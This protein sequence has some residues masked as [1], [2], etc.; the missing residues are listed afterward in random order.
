MPEALLETNG[1][2]KV[3]PIRTTLVERLN[4]HRPTVVAANGVN[5]SIERG[6][7]VAL[8]GQSG[9]GKSTLGRLIARLEEP[10]SGQIILDGQVISNLRGNAL[11]QLRRR[12]QIIFQNPYEALD[13]RYTVL[14]S[15]TEPLQL[16]GLASRSERKEKAISALNDVGLKPP[17]RYLEAY[18]HELSGGQR[19]RVAIARALIVGP[20][21]VVADEAVS[22]LDASVRSGVMNLL[23][24]LQEKRG[25]S[26][27]FIT[28]D[29]AAARYMS[30]RV[31]VMHE[32]SIVEEGPTEEVI[33][34]PKHEYTR[35]LISAASVADPRAPNPKGKPDG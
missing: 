29:L 2:T 34:D 12:I 19:Q 32:G 17:E 15:V 13:P 8:V 3:Y 18:P 25:L 14:R 9:S 33:W 6:E 5:L 11:R 24:D 16:F 20:E 28:H 21:L 27:L 35:R 23:L 26:Y 4:G 10:T 7:V 31:A 22:M 30:E 1:L